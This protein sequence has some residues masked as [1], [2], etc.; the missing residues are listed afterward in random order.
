MT[1]APRHVWLVLFVAACGGGETGTEPPIA[2]APSAATGERTDETVAAPSAAFVAVRAP[3]DESL[4][5]AP[6]RAL[7]G[8]GALEQIAA[9]YPLR[10]VRVHAQSGDRVEAGAPIVEVTSSVVLGAAA[11]Y[12]SSS[13]SLAVLGQ[14]LATVRALRDQRAA[15][16]EQVFELESREADLRTTQ[17]EA[18]AVLRSAGIAPA[19]AAA[20]LARGTITLTS[21]REGI[22]RDMHAVPGEVHPDGRVFATIVT[23]AS[24]RVE[25]RFPSHL[26]EGFRFE[27]EDLFGRRHPLGEGPSRTLEAG[28]EGGVLVWFDL[29]EGTEIA[30]EAP[31]HVH[32]LPTRSTFV[33]VPVGALHP[34][35]S[36]AEVVR[37]RGDTTTRVP[38]RV[39]ASSGSS[40]IVEGDLRVGDQVSSDASGLI[41]SPA[42]GEP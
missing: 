18:L 8:E 2:P 39:V 40:A 17:R 11:G 7:G 38:V 41:E 12:R 6:A 33:E 29:P 36:G 14:R 25:A 35:E 20:A 28:E 37:R 32:A 5:E 22:V 27:F 24:R 10:I 15:S 3:T 9:A 16:A 23:G 13:E 1:R 19:Q 30:P 31:G 42:A 21:T 34:I 4:L 26:A